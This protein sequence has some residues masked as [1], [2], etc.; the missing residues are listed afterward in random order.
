MKKILVIGSLNMDVTLKVPHIP[1]EGETILAKDKSH[2]RGGKGAN[3]AVAI[4]RLGANTSM[5]GAVG[6]D[7][8]GKELLKGLKD[9]GID[10]EGII[11]K[12][13]DTGTAYII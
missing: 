9:E 5:I 8:F 2:N 7:D 1:I 3:Q 6:N 12:E 13:S 4:R 10:T 11:I